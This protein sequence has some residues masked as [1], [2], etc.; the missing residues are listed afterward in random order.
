MKKYNFF[1][2]IFLTLVLLTY[3]YRYFFY[4]YDRLKDM[5]FQSPS[6]E[7]LEFLEIRSS[8]NEKDYDK[9]FFY[10]FKLSNEKLSIPNKFRLENVI[11]TSPHRALTLT[12]LILKSQ[13]IPVDLKYELVNALIYQ[14]DNTFVNEKSLYIK[15]I[16]DVYNSDIF[17]LDTETQDM[18]G[19]EL[20]KNGVM[21]P[22][23][24]FIDFIQDYGFW[25]RLELALEALKFAKNNKIINETYNNL[26]K[27][28]KDIEDMLPKTNSK[29]SLNSE[30]NSET[31][32]HK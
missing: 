3:F 4:S 27:K 23:E 32:H 15:T 6:Y 5:F 20:M 17:F 2:L 10:A 29:S 25:N 21:I 28:I 30:L 11:K 12:S 13:S 26:K 18:L 31:V 9:C 16:R 19:Y 14:D 1:V 8:W 7:I 24:R 22:E